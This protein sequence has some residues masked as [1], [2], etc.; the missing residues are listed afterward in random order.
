M[1]KSILTEI[2]CYH[3][4]D[5]CIDSEISVGEKVFC[6]SGCRTV[7]EI[8]EK[9]NLSRYYTFSTGPGVSQ[10]KSTL[11][12]KFEYLNDLKTSRKLIDFTDG[13]RSTVTFSLP[14]IHCS[15]CIWLLENLYKFDPGI[16]SSRVNF[17]QKKITIRF[18]ED[19]ISLRK[20]AELLSSIGYDPEINLHTIEGRAK[21]AVDKSLYYKTGIAGFCFANIMLLSFPEYLS[22]TDN[23]DTFLKCIFSY[24]IL[25]LSL[26]VFV[27]CSSGY[28]RSALKALKKKVIN[29][30]VPV[31][32]G[33]L[34]L[35]GRSSFE[36]I[37]STG[38]G[39]M[40]SLS[41]LVFFLLLGRMFQNKTYEA[42]SFER[43]YK[44]YFPAS[45]IKKTK[46]RERSIP[47]SSLRAGD[48]IVIRNN[49]LIPADSFLIKG[50]ANIDY[51]F[52]S[53]ESETFEKSEGDI[54]YAGGIQ[55]GAALE[56][57][58]IKE[59]SQSYI[60][61]LWNNSDFLKPEENRIETFSNIAGKYFTIAVLLIAGA[62]GLI[63]LQESTASALN[64]FTSVLIIACPCALAL[65]APFTL[66]N[67]L[68]IFGKNKFYLK[69]TAV[70]EK[71]SRID[72]LV[73][74]KTG[75][76]TKLNEKDI[77]FYGEDLSGEDK[78]IIKSVLYNSTHVLSRSIIKSFP[79]TQIVETQEFT[80]YPG[81]GLEALVK[82]NAVRIGSVSFVL[83]RAAPAVS[84]GSSTS[85]YVS[86]NDEIK[87][88]F[89]SGNSYRE[90]LKEVVQC[91][92]NYN[93][94]LLSGDND[95]E[96]AAL[97]ELLGSNAKLL[98]R[99][100][101]FDKLNYIK[102]LHQKGIRTTMIGD[103][104]NDAGALMKSDV[105]I[106]ISEDAMNFSPACD[107]ILEASE[108]RRLGS[109]L[110]FS[111]MSMKIIYMN[112]FISLLYNAAGIGF[113]VNNS[114]TPVV[115][116]ILMPLS[117]VTVVIAATMSTSLIAKIKGLI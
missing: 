66:G 99:Q 48:R 27:Y 18:D 72:H 86:I 106:S 3:C 29:I 19:L 104:L 67:T 63:W 8:I 69:N 4:G 81:R 39:Y 65:S 26:P 38:P 75:T 117:S 83:N 108:F 89:R 52:V 98:F 111:K 68:R 41:G 114:L 11:E 20:I 7:Y 33:I 30:D 57:E 17:L 60:T 53:G 71:L 85:V 1:D 74:D 49:E 45:V 59:T 84:P 61:Q 10:R 95:G 43:N 116:A 35:F 34:A 79:E 101:P 88:Y 44:S 94:S 90:G 115:S 103:G 107:A 36:I 55:K 112:L 47:L 42:L 110:S 78:E 82:G 97:R 40:D 15:S 13:S 2:K 9:N 16:L 37:S 58:I 109:F 23:V 62:A 96:K 51:S 6:C 46:G 54:I 80:E 76:L 87:G 105:G 25:T 102:M 24:I 22:I 28:F 77:R 31:S 93:V 21:K 50:K 113:A 56:L 12:K 73:F 32:L 5:D 91:L 64:V 92:K 100:S 14:Q 70:I